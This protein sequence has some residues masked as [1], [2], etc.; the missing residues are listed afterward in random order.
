MGIPSYFS[1]IIK[2]YSN[3][4]LNKKQLSQNDICFCN[5]LMDCNSIIYDEFRKLE[6]EFAKNDYDSIYIENKLIHNV[7]NSIGEY[8]KKISPSQLVYIAFDGV[9]PFA[10]MK[11]QRTRRHKG[12]IL[13]KI[14]NTVNKT[15]KPSI[16]STSNI[17]PGTLFMNNLSSK[18]KKA[19]TGLEGHF[20]VKKIIVSGSTENGE[21]EH[22]MFKY[23]RTKTNKV[24]GNTLIYGLG[25]GFNYVVSIPL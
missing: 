4:I 25:L 13:L 3:I 8:I 17:T 12:S 20:N 7:I 9:A 1:Y 16:W 24:C 23:L 15:D 21:G 19:F 10:K 5:L 11:Q 6:E 18:I 22:K 14:S 2:N